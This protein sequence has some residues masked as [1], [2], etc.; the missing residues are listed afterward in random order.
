MSNRARPVHILLIEDNPAD[1]ELMV[2]AMSQS[3]VRNQLTIARDGEAGMEAIYTRGDYAG[4]PQPD[5]I[6]LD[7]N[8]PRLDGREIL[9]QVKSDDAVRHI[10]IVVLTSS[11]AEE[12]VLRSYKLNANSYISK[13]LDFDRFMEIIRR[14][15]DFW[16]EVVKLP[17]RIETSEHSI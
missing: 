15:E 14:L 12:D 16:L 4:M 5:I 17:A 7:L 2:E 6:L 9:A 1:A 3:K 10:P 13:P 8:L 11:Q